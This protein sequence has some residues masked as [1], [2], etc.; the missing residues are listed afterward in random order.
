MHISIRFLIFTLVT[1][2]ALLLFQT[3]QARDLSRGAML[4]ASCEGCHGT[5][6]NSPGAIPSI[7]GKPADYLLEVL[8]SFRSGERESTVMSRHV[9]GYT[10]EEIRLIAEYLA[11]QK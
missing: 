10:E 7:S 1:A 8:E 3:G 4:T 9:K 11:S 6:G 2:I 5:N